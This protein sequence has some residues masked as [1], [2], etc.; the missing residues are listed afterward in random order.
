MTEILLS[1]AVSL[2]I[3]DAEGMTLADTGE[4]L[5]RAFV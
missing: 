1:G 4:C 3:R 2:L 5:R